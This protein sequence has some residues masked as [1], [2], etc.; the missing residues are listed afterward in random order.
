MGSHLNGTGDS[1]EKLKEVLEDK[2]KELKTENQ[3]KPG[4]GTPG[5]EVAANAQVAERS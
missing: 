4:D 2:L 5:N 1:R 3:E